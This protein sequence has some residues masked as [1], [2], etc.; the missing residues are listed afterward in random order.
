MPTTGSWLSAELLCPLPGS[1]PSRLGTSKLE[2]ARD[3]V[4][5]TNTL[6]F[7]VLAGAARVLCLQCSHSCELGSS[8]TPLALLVAG[9]CAS[10]SLTVHC[11]WY[12]DQLGMLSLL[13]SSPAQTVC[14]PRLHAVQQAPFMTRCTELVPWPTSTGCQHCANL[15]QL[16]LSCLLPPSQVP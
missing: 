7:C 6:T 2:C 13:A 1:G 9:N 15:K 10:T 16:G 4:G 11:E 3:S 5:S 12:W 14:V 8:M